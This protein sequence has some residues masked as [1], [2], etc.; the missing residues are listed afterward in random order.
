MSK[1]KIAESSPYAVGVVD[2]K[3]LTKGGEAV[4]LTKDEAQRLEAAG[5]ELEAE[6]A[7]SGTSSS[8]SNSS[9]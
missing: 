3:T 4:D 6:N 7:S 8:S 5:I 1:L 9:S 2:E